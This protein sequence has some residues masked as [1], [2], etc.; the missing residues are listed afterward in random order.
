MEVVG[1]D[2]VDARGV[3]R[4]YPV[5]GVV[6]LARVSYTLSEWV[7]LASGASSLKWQGTFTVEGGAGGAFEKGQHPK[8]EGEYIIGLEDRRRGKIA[9]TLVEK[10][11]G[12][13]KVYHFRG[14]GPLE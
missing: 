13:P 1:T 5:G 6:P 10:Q 7:S 11:A 8:L 14:V 4:L 3:G 2:S 9:I 12:V